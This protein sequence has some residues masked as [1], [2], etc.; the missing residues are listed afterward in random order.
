MID[1]KTEYPSVFGA[2][3]LRAV[4]PAIFTYR[5]FT[6]CM[7]CTFCG[8]ACCSYGVD[9][10]VENIARI[11]ALGPDFERYVGAPRSQWFS[12]KT[13][14]DREFPG[15]ANGR[16]RTKGGACVFLDRQKRGCK[17]HA[18]S[19]ENGIDYHQ[20]KPLVSVLFPLTFEDGALVPASEVTD[21][22]LICGGDG[23]SLYEGVREELAYYFGRAFVEETDAIRTIHVA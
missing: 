4:D 15:G 22:S 11:N 21:K 12:R 17:I 16:T 3:V 8:D 14:K 5:Y 18:Y 13:W 7:S 19:L 10:D 1:L 23:P 9:I 6:H 20:L 2:P